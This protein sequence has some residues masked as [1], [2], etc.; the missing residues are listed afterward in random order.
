MSTRLSAAEI[1]QMYAQGYGVLAIMN[2]TGMSYTEIWDRLGERNM[3]TGG[4]HDVNNC[5]HDHSLAIAHRSG[6]CV[7]PVGRPYTAAQRRALN[8]IPAAPFEGD[9]TKLRADVVKVVW[10]T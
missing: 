6:Q 3:I 8:G 1:K 5:R 9:Y 4:P 7:H 2:Y 10:G